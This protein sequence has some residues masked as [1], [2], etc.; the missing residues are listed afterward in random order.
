MKQ[1]DK[2][3]ENIKQTV[4]YDGKGNDPV[5]L[6][7]TDLEKR[8]K[9][10]ENDNLPRIQ[11]LK[12]KYD[13][14]GLTMSEVNE[15]KREYA[16]N[17]KYSWE[18]RNGES[19]VRSTNIQNKLREW[20]FDKAK[21]FGLEN[22]DEINKNTQAW[23]MYADSLEKK[24]NRAGANNAIG[25]TDW[26]ALSGGGTTNLALFLGKKLGASEKVK[27]AIIK[28]LGKQTKEPIVTP[29]ETKNPIA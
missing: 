28:T 26:I 4:K 10:T 5:Q 29:K 13:T 16:K 2:A 12:Q 3:F 11:E 14:T 21:E 7:L 17:F 15:V 1:A 9:N 8:F 20:Q 22:I 25:I 18:E 27:T 23:K 19:A 6:S 24:L